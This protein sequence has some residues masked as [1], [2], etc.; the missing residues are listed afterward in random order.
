MITNKPQLT[1]S[2]LVS[3]RL[4]SVRRCL[5]SLSPIRDAIS[6]ELILIDT[7]KNSLV[8]EILLEYTDLVYEYEWCRDFARARNEGMRRAKGEWFLFLDDDEWFVEIDELITFFRSGEY[9]KYGYANYQVRNF[10]D[11]EFENYSDCWVT[12]MVCMEKET[13]FVSKI[14]EYIEPLHGKKKNLYIRAN[15]TGYVYATPEERQEH[16]ERNRSL[17]L[18]MIK[19]EPDNIRWRTHLIQEYMSMGE[20]DMLEYCCRESLALF[21]GPNALGW[22]EH[23]GTI[24]V[25]LVGALIN[26]KRYEE[27]VNICQLVLEDKRNSDVLKAYMYLKQGESYFRLG[28]WKAAITETRKYLHALDTTDH[29]S[30]IV[31]K[32]MEP[33]LV[34]DTFGDNNQRIAYSVLICS[35]LEQ[36]SSAALKQYYEK[37]NWSQSSVRIIEGV[38]QYFVRA[39]WSLPYENIFT[40]VMVDVFKNG[41]LRELFCKELL[42]RGEQP[43][44]DFQAIIYV[45]AEALQGVSNGPQN[46]DMLGYYDVLQYYVQVTCQWYDFLQ[47][48][49]VIHLLGEENPAYI[50]AALFISDYLE[51]EGQDVV[52]ALG[53]LRDAV[54]ILPD[55]ASGIGSYLHFYGDLEKQRVEKQKK[56]MEELRIQVI[57]Q[58]NAMLDSGQIEAATQIIGQLKQMFPGDL[59]V[60]SLAL[61]VRINC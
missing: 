33:I 39:I 54:E 55:F 42:A 52:Q 34:N 43:L 3:D 31:L 15:H 35:G 57:G 2:L 7:S 20:W 13:R 18:E 60:A 53:C 51:T 49:G 29:N 45:F 17:L 58:V 47:E 37:L 41:V 14:H 5:D 6:C 11:K 10:L 32:Q 9:K 22:S 8:H 44:K 23:I 21:E 50:Q 61:E 26:Q 16:F 59:E 46:G 25:G 4:D 30:S 36:N 1:I 24:Y 28:K 48:Q 38:E 27:S 19:E 40:Q 12:R 56:E